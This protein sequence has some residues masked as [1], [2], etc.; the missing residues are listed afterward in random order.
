[1]TRPESAFDEGGKEGRD[2]S[3]GRS[4]TCPG[5]LHLCVATPPKRFERVSLSRGRQVS[6][7][8]RGDNRATEAGP[9]SPACDLPAA[10][11]GKFNEAITSTSFL[12]LSDHLLNEMNVIRI[13]IF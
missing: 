3:P 2:L 11:R 4:V 1:M 8:P 10:T 9:I 13:I 7:F 12:S 5:I 6:L